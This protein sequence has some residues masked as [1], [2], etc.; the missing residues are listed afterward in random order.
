MRQNPLQSPPRRDKS[1]SPEL[2]LK[3]VDTIFG[4]EANGNIAIPENDVRDNAPF[5]FPMEVVSTTLA[6]AAENVD[7]GQQPCERADSEPI[8]L[9]SIK[10]REC[11]IADIELV[12]CVD[13]EGW[14]PTA[15]RYEWL[16]ENQPVWS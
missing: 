14:I 7:E 5:T 15:P 6:C 13:I 2:L 9:C 11:G 12:I 16:P 4:T 10:K 8:L 3:L 1:H